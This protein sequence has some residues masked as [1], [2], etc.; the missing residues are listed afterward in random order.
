MNS[1]LFCGRPDPG[2]GF[3]GQVNDS[4]EAIQSWIS[5]VPGVIGVP[6]QFG[7]IRRLSTDQFQ[8]L[9]PLAAQFFAYRGA[10][11]ASGTCEEKF[12]GEN[13]VVRA[14]N[15]RGSRFSVF[16]VD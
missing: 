5:K 9:M 12:H 7:F 10:Y 4:R 1:P 13:L 11:E 8:K 2:N 14:A 6:G 16:T 15:G 3:T